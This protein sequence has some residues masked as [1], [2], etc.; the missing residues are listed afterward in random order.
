[1][2]M[3]KIT[4]IRQYQPCACAWNE[5]N[6]Q[7]E[8]YFLIVLEIYCLIQHNNNRQYNVPMDYTYIYIHGDH[9]SKNVVLE[10]LP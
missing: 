10:K 2:T 9:K 8:M 3:T 4:E 1:M 6:F 7:L 5:K